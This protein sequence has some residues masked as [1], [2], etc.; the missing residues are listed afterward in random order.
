M[1]AV[2]RVSGVDAETVGRDLQMRLMPTAEASFEMERDFDPV[3]LVGLVLAGVQTVKI[4]WDWWVSARGKRVSVTLVLD[5][6]R[7]VELEGLER[8]DLATMLKT[9]S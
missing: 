9:E 5:D 3:A 2:V 8:S 4:V 6:G 1:N 7:V